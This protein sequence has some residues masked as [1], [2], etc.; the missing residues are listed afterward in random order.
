[1]ILW[2]GRVVIIKR[3]HCQYKHIKYIGKLIVKFKI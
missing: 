3:K 1:M 2:N